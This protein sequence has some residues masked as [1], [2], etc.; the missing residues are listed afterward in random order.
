MRN[1]ALVVV[2]ML[3]AAAP[4]RAADWAQFRGPNSSGIAV[5]PAPPIE[6]GPGKNELWKVSLDSGHSSPCVVGD[7]IFLTTYDQPKKQ[8]AVVCIAR[9]D[10]KIRWSRTVSAKQ[11][12]KGHPSFNPASSTPTSDGQR[13]VAYFGS[14]GLVCFDMDG[15]KLWD[16]PLPLAQ[17]YGGA[18]T[19]PI[20]VGDRV[21]LYRATYADHYLLALDKKTGK[22]IWKTQQAAR[23]TPNV[24]CTATPIVAGD[25]LILHSVH[26]IQGFAV[27]DG[28]LLWQ[29]NLSATATSTPVLAGKEVIVATWTQTGEPALVPK[30]PPYEEL[31]KANDKNGDKLIGRGEM[32]RLMIFHRPEG[33]EAPANGA[34]L[35]FE[36]VDRNRNGKINA[37]EWAAWRAKSGKRRAGYK[38]HGMVA[39]NIEGQGTL[40][41]DQIRTLEPQGIPEVPSPLYH[42]GYVYFVKNGGI[43]TCLELKTGKRVYR[44]R[45]GGS[46]TH[47]ASPIIAGGMLMTIS[48]DGQM[49]VVRLGPDAE[50]LASNKIGE[51]IY[52]TPAIVDG[53]IYVRT[54]KT[55]FAFSADAR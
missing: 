20:I 51:R 42:E 11:I 50:V 53:V 4:A 10:G 52:A 17:S 2:L 37:V 30:Y 26:A 16:V 19:S 35:R 44:M 23:F 40:K 13:V 24:A 32:P 48:G 5:G 1:S 27:S 18:A 45:T 28:K 38:H 41:P 21:I 14:F 15:T 33:T 43:L 22:Q 29:A 55:L 36:R 8:L 46:G 7:S 34:P 39:I 54:H 25:Q 31:L 47:Y 12:E 49:S 3:I 9:A 6:F